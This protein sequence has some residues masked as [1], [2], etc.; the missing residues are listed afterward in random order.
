MEEIVDLFFSGSP[1]RRLAGSCVRKISERGKM[2]TIGSMPLLGARESSSR[3]LGRR[4]GSLWSQHPHQ[5]PGGSPKHKL[6]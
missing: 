1:Q 2:L 6:G 5:G 4:G 3:I